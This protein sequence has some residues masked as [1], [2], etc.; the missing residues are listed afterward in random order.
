ME[1]KE[2]LEVLGYNFVNENNEIYLTSQPIDV[3]IG[4][5][6]ITINELITQYLEFNE[7]RQTNKR[8][9]IAASYACKSAIKTG[10]N[11]SN[12]EIKQL[13]IDLFNCKT[14]YVCPH[15][16]PVILNLTLKE[17]DYKFKRS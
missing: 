8:D 12:I 14:P 16:R 2:E 7:I 13:I 10:Y 15:G 3:A 6:N 17:I 1:L 11:A 4:E 5:Q 9:N